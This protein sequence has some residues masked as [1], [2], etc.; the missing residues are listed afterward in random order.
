MA[1]NARGRT[2]RE[3]AKAIA[4]DLPGVE[5]TSHHG[6]LDMRV[7]NR[8]FATFPAEM[9]VVNLR[10]TPETL[11]E[12]ITANPDVYARV[13]GDHWMQVALEKIDRTKLQQLLTD[14]WKLVGHA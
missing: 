2:D 6:T 8:T 1:R 9:K 4:L 5:L 13:R 3:A 11:A 7:N 10:C 14:A 12:A